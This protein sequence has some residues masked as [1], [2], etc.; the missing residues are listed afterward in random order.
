[1]QDQNKIPE[2]F[3]EVKITSEFIDSEAK[4]FGLSKS[5][6]YRTSKHN[7]EVG[8]VATS[9]HLIGEAGDYVGSRQKE[10]LK[11]LK[12]NYGVKG[13]DEG[14]HAHIET[15]LENDIP[16][17]FSLASEEVKKP[18]LSKSKEL[19]HKDIWEK[20]ELSKIKGDLVSMGGY[21][22][23]LKNYG[24][25]VGGE[26][27]TL[28]VKP[29]KG[30]GYEFKE[31]KP[32]TRQSYLANKEPSLKESLLSSKVNP[33]YKEDE[34]PLLMYGA[35]SKA[36][37][38]IAGIL[39][40]K[41]IPTTGEGV[42][43]LAKLATNTFDLLFPNVAGRPTLSLTE[44]YKETLPYE[45]GAFQLSPLQRWEEMRKQKGLSV[46]EA[47]LDPE[48][49]AQSSLALIPY[50]GPL[51]SQMGKELES[52]DYTSASQT[53]IAMVLPLLEHK[54]VSLKNADK[55]RD[56]KF[57]HSKSNP[58]TSYNA[59]D[60]TIY[61]NPTAIE[62][63]AK[64]GRNPVT[65]VDEGLKH[66]L[67]HIE[68]ADTSDEGKV[69][70]AESA[71]KV[72][73]KD[74]A[75]KFK[76]DL[77]ENIEPNQVDEEKVVEHITSTGDQS[78]GTVKRLK[79]GGY[80]SEDGTI[81]KGKGSKA[82]AIEHN[83]LLKERGIESPSNQAR[84]DDMWSL[85]ATRGSEALNYAKRKGISPAEEAFIIKA[86]EQT[87]NGS[88]MFVE[89][90]NKA[91]IQAYKENETLSKDNQFEELNKSDIPSDIP[92]GFTEVTESQP[93]NVKIPER[94]HLES[95]DNSKASDLEY[96]KMLSTS[97]KT[98]LKKGETWRDRALKFVE[99]QERSAAYKIE[100]SKIESQPNIDESSHAKS[101]GFSDYEITK[102]SDSTFQ[103]TKSGKI[104]DAG[105]L[106]DATPELVKNHIEGNNTF[107]AKAKQIIENLKA[108]KKNNPNP[109]ISDIRKTYMDLPHEGDSHI[110][111][112]EEGIANHEAT[113]RNNENYSKALQ[114]Q[115]DRFNQLTESNGGTGTGAMK[116]GALQKGSLANPNPLNPD[117]HIEQLRQEQERIVS[118]PN[119]S[120]SSEDYS[121]KERAEKTFLDLKR[122][123]SS[124]LSTL[125][126]L[127]KETWAKRNPLTYSG[128]HSIVDK[129]Q[130]DVQISL[131]YSKRYAHDTRK[132]VPSLLRRE[133]ISRYIDSGGDKSIL[134]RGA[135]S[136]TI[137]KFSKKAYE[138]A[139]N[140][141]PTEIELANQIQSYYDSM[142]QQGLDEGIL[143]KQLQSYINR[144]YDK[145]TASILNTKIEADF[146][147]GKLPTKFAH[148]RQR[149]YQ[150][151][152][153]AEEK[154]LRAK[155]TD[156][157]DLVAM[158]NAEFYNTLAAR[159]FV[160]NSRSI[161]APDGRP[162]IAVSGGAGIRKLSKTGED[163][164]IVNSHAKYMKNVDVS[165]YKEINHPS[166]RKHKYVT[167]SPDGTIVLSEGNALVHPD[168][169][170]EFK[171]RLE[172]S[173]FENYKLLRGAKFAKAQLKAPKL[174][175]SA[176][177]QT[178]IDQHA[179]THRLW[180]PYQGFNDTI[181]P[182][183]PKVQKAVYSGVKLVDARGI[184]AF[185]EG[186]SG[187]EWIFKIPL[188]GPKL[189]AYTTWLFED[190]IPK[191]KLMY[192]DQ[193][194]E[195][196]LKAY[197]GKYSEPQIARFTA[198]ETNNSFG[199]LN[200][201]QLGR[202]KTTQD[203]L[204]FVLL[205]PDFTEA[206]FRYMAQALLPYGR[207]QRMA[208]AGGA[209]AMYIGAKTLNGLFNNGDM[210]L[211][212]KDHLFEV[213][214]GEK[215]VGIRSVQEDILNIMQHPGQSFLNRLNPLLTAGKIAVEGRD[216]FGEK[217]L[218]SDSNLA[219]GKAVAS[220]ALM[221]MVYDP[222]L[223]RELLKVLGFSVR[224]FTDKELEEAYKQ[225]QKQDEQKKMLIKENRETNQ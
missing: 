104:W 212:D 15:K 29:P 146:Q 33:P 190:H 26:G 19:A 186:V 161:I 63:A 54:L 80:S 178:H 107:I 93:N 191:I 175:F 7:K 77:D 64:E 121:L 151:L 78:Y 49:V 9:K 65:V 156:V 37:D 129:W 211:N 47:Y 28:Y 213:K 39:E 60:R 154:G 183:D 3:S 11:H 174:A 149:F 126:N 35:K 153:D 45:L 187:N 17:G 87:N 152:I 120:L 138:T 27:S 176:F 94:Q 196:N 55:L 199:E 143:W 127:A 44:H 214:I 204:S 88:N 188:A 96:K 208:L 223:D 216:R 225:K 51:A 79:G 112:I 160:A 170:K 144:I 113:I 31:E 2:G 164:V 179:L 8:G 76:K 185:A 142:M 195:R 56:I 12:D 140:L 147:G 224:K 139:L 116:A 184:S 30:S 24:W 132:L 203:M 136:T 48:M 22:S 18:K 40:R 157:A 41:G 50:F 108:L 59:I 222:H 145:N 32:F 150:Y 205:A 192:F 109:S 200:L 215:W 58:V 53:A 42:K 4:K 52:K 70:L 167:T 5:S 99:S 217:I 197:S 137:D 91:A 106:V 14:N 166:F 16:E 110:T 158:Y 181:N 71:D 219:L 66:E 102:Q 180:N 25:E 34:T 141:T 177:H 148:A 118:D 125:K 169:V 221:P 117:P 162:V 86:M 171:N 131:L 189:Q 123:I 100:D 119:A 206:R 194:Y 122:N 165:D 172:G 173:M 75:D 23:Q 74:N 98:Q 209:V 124:T 133:A 61:I 81:F 101:L 193:A 207:E 202:H 73:S 6:G 46:L 13:L 103:S 90:A 97:T 20:F 105:Q 62:E 220:E 89:G 111:T 210:N 21:A 69:K 163:A 218:P 134:Q 168:Y 130:G 114:I 36:T 92:E 128:F 155:T 95:L 182:S 82:K 201:E 57:D 83:R 68:V 1:M 38:F 198:D 10:F 67:G 43:H 72:L 85:V 115:G 135:N 84:F 159:E